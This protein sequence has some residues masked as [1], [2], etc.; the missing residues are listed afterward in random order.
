M[1]FGTFN[2]KGFEQGLN[3]IVEMPFINAAVIGVVLN[4]ALPEE[5][6]TGNEKH[7]ILP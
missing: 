1:R 4:L 5:K 2:T 7:D 3:L 6:S